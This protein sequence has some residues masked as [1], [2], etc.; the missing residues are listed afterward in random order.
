M[1][2]ALLAFILVATGHP[3]C[4]NLAPPLPLDAFSHHTKGLFSIQIYVT[5]VREIVVTC[6]P[7]L[8]EAILSIA[9]S[10]SWNLHVRVS[11]HMYIY[12]HDNQY[13]E[14]IHLSLW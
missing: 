12:H 7:G 11:R 4:L 5:C 3:A 8:Q 2:T 6:I 14:H 9:S 13:S 10:P 1:A